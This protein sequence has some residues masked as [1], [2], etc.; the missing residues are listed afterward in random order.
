LGKSRGEQLC[1]FAIALRNNYFEERQLWGI[2]LENNFG[3]L[4]SATFLGETLAA[5]GSS[6]VN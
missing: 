5:L 6:F 3:K 1:G 2:S 4:F